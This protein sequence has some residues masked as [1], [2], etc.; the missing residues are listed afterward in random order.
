M[1]KKN[2]NRDILDLY[3]ESLVNPALKLP[4]QEQIR[5]DRLKEVYA[6]WLANPLLTD[7]KIRDY[8]M[9][10]YSLGRA[11]AY[12]DIAVVKVIFGLVQKSDKE[13]IRYKANHL[14]ELAAAAAMAGNDKKAKALEK[15]AATMAKVNQLDEPEGEEIPWDDMKPKDYSFSIDPAVIGIEKE[16]N[17]EEKSRKLLA[18]YTQEID[19]SID[20]Q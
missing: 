11:Q 12:N 13:F 15:I 7:G 19:G 9:S 20:E 3:S 4:L 18:Q 10:R 17:I 5:L 14:L 6:H 2:P 8:I 1:A 16:P